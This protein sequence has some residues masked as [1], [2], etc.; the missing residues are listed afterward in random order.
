MLS[1]GL[2]MIYPMIFKGK[3]GVFW[4]APLISE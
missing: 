2:D 1:K 4:A 3:M